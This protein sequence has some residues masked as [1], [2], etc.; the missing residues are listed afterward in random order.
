LETSDT[1]RPARPLVWLAGTLGAGT[2]LGLTTS[3]GAGLAASAAVSGLALVAFLLARR[4]SAPAWTSW[5]LVLSFARASL[6]DAPPPA[7]SAVTA[8][9]ARELRSSPIAGRWHG[10]R[11]GRTGWLEPFH[12][13]GSEA[14]RRA[15]ALL[16]E[17]E[18][19]PPADGTPVAVLPGSEVVPWPRGPVPSPR[20]RTRT[21]AALAPVAPDELVRLGPPPRAPWS[22]HSS[23]ACETFLEEL[24]ALR[25]AVGARVARVERGSSTGL[26]RA[27]VIGARDG[28]SQE[29]IDL[30]ARTGTSHLLAIS[31]WQV[32]LFGALV[33]LPLARVARSS[34][35]SLVTRAL[36][37]AFFAA[38]AGA[39][40]PVLRATLALVL[41][42][43]AVLRAR[44][45][46]PRR[47]DGLSFLAAAFALE[48][49][50][51]PAGIRTPALSLSYA[52]TLGLILGTGTLGRT[53]RAPAEPWAELAPA[54]WTRVLA[55]RLRAWL[56]SG[57]AAS[58]AAVLATL[59][60]TWSTFGEFAPAG[61]V[62]TL[63]ALPPFTFLSLLAWL[64]ALAPWSGLS[65]P[66]ELGTRA[67]YGLLELGDALPGTP[68]L[69]PPRPAGLLLA[70]T[71]LA[72]LGLERA[73]ARRAAALLW[74]LLLLPWS[75]APRGLELH[76]LDA[77]HGSAAVLR[78]PGV[79]ALVFD[80]GSRDRRAL[81]SE[82]LL[83]LLARWEVA[84][85]S[86]V[87][88]HPD[89]DHASG[90]PRLCERVRVDRWLGAEP[91]Q[92]PVRLPHDALRIDLALG[93][94]AL[95]AACPALSLALLRGS[96]RDGNEG[97]RALEIAWR[98]ERALLLGDAEEEGLEGLPIE[99]GSLRLLLAPHHG[100]D[101]SRLGSLLERCPPAEVW[102]SASEDP[103]IA[104]ELERRGIEWRW[105]GRDGPLALRLP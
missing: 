71:A 55:A 80:A 57:L 95:E 74:G 92:D 31:G 76:L 16:F 15:Q 85:A 20:N 73:L 68:L 9:E 93:R 50:L 7:G 79:E 10:E 59:P 102:I 48:C 11:D 38:L 96:A 82:A 22:W 103:P 77:G 94:L 37:L 61:V 90:L 21:F 87:L 35:A 42:Q 23:R 5:V 89:H 47:P 6:V 70:A 17:P 3:E 51:D 75:A 67:L 25:A 84:R 46:P 65:L 78:A 36:L 52:A 45:A 44:P 99:P 18:C 83:P 27:L 19:A 49:L 64:A 40:K 43:L 100:S 12:A 13:D 1:S 56:A 32:W 4:G 8:V 91:A 101:A 24:H 54:R 29:R 62:L 33:V 88:S 14:D 97:S 34:P 86:V 53:L 58:A 28:L 66:A 2:Y 105:T 60:L 39:E 41:L 30:F 98:G 69:L 104:G 72:F 81:A 63:L 26:L